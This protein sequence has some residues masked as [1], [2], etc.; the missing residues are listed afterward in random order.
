MTIYNFIGLLGLAQG[1]LMSFFIL[2]N[3]IFKN[4]LNRHFAFFLLILVIIGLDNL[5]CIH[6]HKLNGFWFTFF[7]IVGDDIPWVLMF[8]LPLF[9]FFLRAAQCEIKIPLKFFYIPF[10]IFLGINALIDLDIDF[11]LLSI[12]SLTENRI[13]LYD[14]EQYIALTLSLCLHLFVFFFVIKNVS[15]KWIIKLWWYCSGLT[16]LW[17]TLTLGDIFFDA[18]SLE[19]VRSLLWIAVSV[20]IYWLIYTGLF[21]FNLANNRELLK[22]KLDENIS[23]TDSKKQKVKISVSYFH[24]LIDLMEHDAIYRDP[25][26]SREKVA[27][28]LA[29][30]N[31]YLTQLIKEHTGMSFTSFTNQYRVKE[32]EKMLHDTSYENFDVVSIGLEAGFKSKSA[33]FSTFKKL[34]GITP[35]QFRKKMS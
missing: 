8:Y 33:F 30:S 28:Q 18:K 29:I 6:Y 32:V 22:E 10:W 4:P 7:D 34:N 16:L 27:E 5:L 3:K 19:I 24:K 17:A 31:S 9:A 21:Q 26:M 14:F 23:P 11:N 2:R 25:D 15:N 12:P 20:F 1:V 35:K 13:I